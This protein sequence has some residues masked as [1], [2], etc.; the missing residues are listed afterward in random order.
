MS[1]ETK[2]SVPKLSADGSNW[3]IYRDRM[4]WAM[5]S[6]DLA[7]HLTNDMMPTAY[8]AAGTIGGVTAPAR[9]AAGERTVKHAIAA[10]VP[11]SVFNK[12]KS[13]TRAKDAWDALK[14][15]FEG[16]SQM[17]SVDLLSRTARPTW[18]DS[19]SRRGSAYPMTS[20]SS[21]SLC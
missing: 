7:D 6:R 3:V 21:L 10:S 19:F 13:S 2:I 14:A 15:S 11:D 9:W 8:G 17:I 12:I 20:L 16:R 1:D 4:V 5:D 18:T